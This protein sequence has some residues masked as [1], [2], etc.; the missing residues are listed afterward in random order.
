LFI[1]S[2]PSYTAVL[3]GCWIHPRLFND[4]CGKFVTG[5]R[6]GSSRSRPAC[7]DALSPG[8]LSQFFLSSA[9]YIAESATE[10]QCPVVSIPP[11]CWADVPFKHRAEDRLFWQD[12]RISPHFFRYFLQIFL[13]RSRF[14]LH[15]FKCVINELSYY[16]KIYNLGN[17]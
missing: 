16:P 5:H 8:L 4:V 11:S 9:H 2:P 15:P 12:F 1:L 13:R 17:W 7:C 3:D 10:G 14:V 6:I